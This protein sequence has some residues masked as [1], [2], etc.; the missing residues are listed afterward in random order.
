MTDKRWLVQQDDD[1]IY[2][3]IRHASGNTNTVGRFSGG[4]E[5]ADYMVELMNEAHD[6][7]EA[8]RAREEAKAASEAEEQVEV[9]HLANKNCPLNWLSDRLEDT[10]PRSR[11]EESFDMIYGENIRRFGCKYEIRPKA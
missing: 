9:W 10:G 1:R 5:D 7:R 2:F 6:A 3:C 4:R 8:A 11:I